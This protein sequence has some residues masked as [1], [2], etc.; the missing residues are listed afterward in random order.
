[1]KKAVESRS[2]WF[3]AL[4][5]VTTVGT[6][7][8]ADEN[9][10]SLLGDNIGYITGLMALVGLWLRFTTS[11]AIEPIIK[12]KVVPESNLDILNSDIDEYGV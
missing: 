11:K 9:F 6:A 10:K 12:K 3:Y 8:L 4:S 1:M 5:I 7:L 2:I